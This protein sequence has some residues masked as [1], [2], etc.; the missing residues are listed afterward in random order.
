[1]LIVQPLGSLAGDAIERPTFGDEEEKEE[2][3]E[4]QEEEEK[5]EEREAV[6]VDDISV[7]S[8]LLPHLSFNEEKTVRHPPHSSS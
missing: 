4:E 7:N 8:D 2:E 3:E 6:P 5:E 1:M